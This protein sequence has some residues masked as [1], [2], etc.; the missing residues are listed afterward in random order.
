MP[1]SVTLLLDTSASVAG[2]RL[3]HLA[4]AGEGLVDALRPDDRASLITFSHQVDLRR[5]MTGDKAAVRAALHAMSGS[6]ATA[7]RDAYTPK[8]AARAG[9]HALE[10]RLRSGRADVTARPG[11]FVAAASPSGSSRPR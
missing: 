8:G 9:W 2:D 10:V 3:A 4:Q 5:P 6:G 1:L 7:P 11:Y